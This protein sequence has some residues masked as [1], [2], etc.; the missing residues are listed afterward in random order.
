MKNNLIHHKSYAFAIR[1]VN[2]YK[3]LVTE[4]KESVLSKQVLKWYG[5]A[6][7]DNCSG[8]LII[9]NCQLSIA[10]QPPPRCAVLP[11]SRGRVGIWDYFS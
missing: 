7:N 11:L 1:I 3:Y 4:Q 5:Y 8:Q 2:L 6:Q 10:K 9:I